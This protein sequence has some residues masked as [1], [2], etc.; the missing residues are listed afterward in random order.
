M[1][2]DKYINIIYQMTYICRTCSQ[3]YLA[4]SRVLSGSRNK[5]ILGDSSI[6]PSIQKG[7]PHKLLPYRHC[8]PKFVPK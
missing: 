7:F 5:N 3:L 1:E 6:C 2:I 4:Q 8:V